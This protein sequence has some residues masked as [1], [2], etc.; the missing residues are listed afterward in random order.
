[1][2]IPRPGAILKSKMKK[3]PIFSS[4]ISDSFTFRLEK[5]AIMPYFLAVFI[6]L[7]TK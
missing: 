7:F 1:M 2:N 4:I 3:N 5:S 6:F